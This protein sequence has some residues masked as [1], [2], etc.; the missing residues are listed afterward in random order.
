M[1]KTLLAILILILPSAVALFVY[2]S[3]TRRAPTSRDAVGQVMTIAGS[4]SPGSEDGPATTAAFSDPFGV[5]VDH[6]GNVIIA[7]AGHSNRIRIITQDG[8]KTIAGSDEGFR[9]GDALRAQFNTP[10]GI[11]ID[12]AGNIIVADTSNNR[13]RK[14]SADART[15][16]T[17]AGSGAAGFKNGSAAEA[18]FDGPIA[19]TVDRKGN[20]F[21]ADTYNDSIRKISADGNVTTMAG[22]GSPGFADGVGASAMFDTPCGVAADKEGNLFVADTGNHAIRKVTPA[23][24]VSTIARET[25]SGNEAVG[26]RLDQPVGI[27]VTHDGFL[28]IADEGRGRI[29]R[30]TPDGEA[31]VYAGKGTGFAEGVGADARFSGPRGIAIDRHGNLYVADTDNYI[32]REVFPLASQPAAERSDT[33]FIQPAGEAP[34]MRRLLPTLERSA[35][36]IGDSFPW[37]LSRQDQWH[38]VAG[39]VGEARGAPG[40][41]ALDHI[42][43]G[44]DIHG[45]EGEPAL[46]VFAEK[47]SSPIANWDFDGAS[48]GVHVGLFSYI[49]IRV[50]RNARDEISAPDKFKARTDST[51]KLIGVRVRRG[52]KFE[53]G[54]VIGS[55][56]RLN[57]VHLNLG[58]WN[59]QAN[60]LVLPFFGFKDTVAPTIEPNGIEAC[61]YGALASTMSWET[62]RQLETGQ[63]ETRNGRLA[64]KGDVAIV[65]TAYDR[66]DGNG[67]NRKL[68]IYRLGYQ[69]LNEDRTPVKGFEQPRINIEF[70][71]LPPEDRS[72]FKVYAPGSGVSAYGTPT[73]FKYIVTNRVRDGEARDGF[74][75]TASLASGNYIIKVIAE[76]YAG[77][78]ASGKAT[79]LAIAIAN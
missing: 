43:S 28:F 55:L 7:D 16:S 72:V 52:T 59:A 51:G 20:I 65:V 53:A 38:E 70:N 15:V 30:L 39:V 79:E 60:P 33:P 44:L 46:S 22:S 74:L 12:K 78:R 41:I 42:H 69:L 56:N 17:I 57:H 47:V 48:E 29:V 24:D 68:G 75:R 8:V 58:P 27:V 54:D 19:V 6:R 73:R 18:Q 62:T 4:G 14:L 40:G 36:G 50:G 25:E 2:L 49:H 32:V 10:S 77:N 71:H 67:A 61:P 34:P 37:P 64:V 13:I 5:A 9:D 11:A 63:F 21:V 35:L 31:G 45:N 3:V 26:V 66:V 1:R 23:G 76:D